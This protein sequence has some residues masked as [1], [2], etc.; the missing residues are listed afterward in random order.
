M[1]AG[2]G[3]NCKYRVSAQT[4]VDICLLRQSGRP[5]CTL[6]TCMFM[7]I[8]ASTINRVGRQL[9]KPTDEPQGARG[10]CAQTLYQMCI[11]SHGRRMLGGAGRGERREGQT[12]THLPQQPPF[13]LAHSWVLISHGHTR[14]TP[15]RQK[16]CRRINKRAMDL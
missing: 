15:R 11:T 6:T 9:G 14:G 3:M 8:P 12:Q 5:T 4:E 1:L 10:R 7:F 13:L 16:K 2:P